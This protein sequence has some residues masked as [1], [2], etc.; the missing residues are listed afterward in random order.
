MQQWLRRKSLTRS[1]RSFSIESTVLF[2]HYHRI[3]GSLLFEYIFLAYFHR[4]RIIPLVWSDRPFSQLIH[5][6]GTGLASSVPINVF[7]PTWKK[8][9]TR[10]CLLEAAPSIY[11]VGI[12]HGAAPALAEFRYN[13]HRVHPAYGQSA[14][15]WQYVAG[16]AR[17]VD[18]PCT[19]LTARRQTSQY[20]CT[21]GLSV[22]S[23]KCKECIR[24]VQKIQVASFVIAPVSAR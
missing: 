17:G 14:R 7:I 3:G 24:T 23:L 12:S 13:L 9:N 16:S 20:F 4:F 2:M 19:S 21:P 18:Y 11:S 6:P 22:S 1:R 5:Y 8:E 10:P 15:V